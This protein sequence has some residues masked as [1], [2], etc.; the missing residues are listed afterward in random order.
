MA[1]NGPA[2]GETGGKSFSVEAV[3]ENKKAALLRGR[4]AEALSGPGNLI[5]GLLSMG[6]CQLTVVF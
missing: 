4:L 6:L 1:M 5:P 2:V 3:K